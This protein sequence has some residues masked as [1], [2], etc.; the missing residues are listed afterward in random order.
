MAPATRRAHEREVLLAR[1]PKLSRDQLDEKQAALRELVDGGGFPDSERPESAGEL[2]GLLDVL[3]RVPELAGTMVAFSAHL[4]A[5]AVLDRRLIELAICIAASH[6]RT[7]L[8]FWRHGRAAIAHG[9]NAQI[10]DDLRAR[11]EPV[12]DVDDERLVHEVTTQMLLANE[13]D[14]ETYAAAIEFFGERALV[15]LVAALGFYV[16]IGMILNVFEVAVPDVGSIF[17]RRRVDTASEIRE[18]RTTPDG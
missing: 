13:V 10:I 3:M 12:F 16:M 15:E 9:I 18:S 11:R 7:D 2:V 8:T 14:D 17:N 4:R 1:M 6:S 5:G